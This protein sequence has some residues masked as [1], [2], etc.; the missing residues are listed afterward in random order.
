MVNKEVI[1][2]LKK[3]IQLLNSEGISVEKAYLFGS[4]STGSASE[5]SDIDVMLVS[6]TY[7]ENDDITFGKAWL[8]TRKINTKIEP[9]LVSRRSFE[10]ESGSPL[11]SLVKEQGIEFM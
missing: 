1:E 8:L 7:D 6:D 11:I 10:K 9:Y 4:Y 2:M 3:Y 5:N